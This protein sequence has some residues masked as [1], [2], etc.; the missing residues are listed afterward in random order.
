MP[1]SHRTTERAEGRFRVLAVD[2]YGI[3][4]GLTEAGADALRPVT[5]IAFDCSGLAEPVL[6]PAAQDNRTVR[7]AARLRLEHSRTSAPSRPGTVRRR[8]R[9]A[10]CRLPDARRHD[11]TDDNGL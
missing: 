2:T 8:R 7:E 10:T 9:R 4:L 11:R 1:D 6:L 3:A 5:R